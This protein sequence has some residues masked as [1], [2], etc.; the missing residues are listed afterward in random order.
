[1][2]DSKKQKYKDYLPNEKKSNIN[3]KAIKL[4]QKLKDIQFM[5]DVKFRIPEENEE[6]SSRL[7][8]RRREKL[9]ENNISLINNLSILVPLITKIKYKKN[10]D[11]IV[12]EL[13]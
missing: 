1:M 10:I 9:S 8:P 5:S 12:F 3:N 11:N 7:D 13:V 4:N 2:Q 6:V